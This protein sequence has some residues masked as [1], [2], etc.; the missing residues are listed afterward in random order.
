MQS[1]P[2]S[3][4]PWLSCL[5]V[6][7]GCSFFFVVTSFLVGFFILSCDDKWGFPHGYLC[8]LGL[9]EILHLLP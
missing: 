6:C 7:F 8:C 3:C 5:S 1:G 4:R 2:K 9:P